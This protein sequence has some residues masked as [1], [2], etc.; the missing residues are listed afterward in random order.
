MEI[1]QWHIKTFPSEVRWTI[2]RYRGEKKEKPDN[3]QFHFFQA[4]LGMVKFLIVLLVFEWFVG[5]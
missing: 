5:N 4:V 2:G 1:I 3:L